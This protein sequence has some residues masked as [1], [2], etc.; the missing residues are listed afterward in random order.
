MLKCIGLQLP[1]QIDLEHEGFEMR[2]SDP[3]VIVEGIN[4]NSFLKDAGIEVCTL[5]HL[6]SY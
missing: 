2:L 3:Y 5:V 1:G 6:Q 4:D